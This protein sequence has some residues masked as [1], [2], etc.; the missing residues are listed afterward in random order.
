VK[1]L[2]KVHYDNLTKRIFSLQKDNT[3]A[4]KEL[5]LE[6]FQLQYNH[7]KVYRA[8]TNTLHIDPAVVN[9]LDRIP[10]L[11]IS[12]FKTQRVLT[13]LTEQSKELISF[14]SSGTT[15]TGNSFHYVSDISLY[16][17]SFMQC[18][19][20]FFGKPEELCILALL[21]SYLERGG[22]SLVYMAQHLINESK[23]VQ[24]GFYLDNLDELIT[25]INSLK[26]QK[27]KTLLLG[28]SYAL[29]D[30]ADKNI[31]LP[32]NFLVME[33][34]GMKGRR[35]E[36]LKEELHSILKEKFKTET[37][38]SEYGMTELLSQGYSMQDGLFN[39]PPWMRILTRDTSDPLSYTPL[40]KT[41]G[42]N[43]IDLANLNS[44]AFIATQ[45]LGKLHTPDSFELMG[46]FDNSDIRGCNLLVT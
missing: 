9:R 35:K 30:L 18:F 25:T 5:A 44:C 23:H 21:P 13:D 11:P 16:E 24:S 27:Q 38:S 37:I 4:F 40:N 1:V 39:M 17:K 34:G 3:V 8:F 15:Q 29:L 45:D 22:S 42:L 32:A 10:F 2:A 36:M 12:F 41:G 28:V 26:Q 31:E 14:S 7:N 43:V 33:T 46:R 6:V 20:L 19:N